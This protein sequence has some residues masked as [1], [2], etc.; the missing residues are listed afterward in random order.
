MAAC[1]SIANVILAVLAARTLLGDRPCS[2]FSSTIIIYIHPVL[3]VS[4]GHA[5]SSVA[6]DIPDRDPCSTQHILRHIAERGFGSYAD[7][8]AVFKIHVDRFN[9][10]S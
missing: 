6:C 8:E 2:N 3:V 1:G 7:N 10:T 4:R 5:N 9:H